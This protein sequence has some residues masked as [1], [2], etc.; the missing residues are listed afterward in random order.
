MYPFILALKMRAVCFCRA[1]VPTSVHSIKT[2]NNIIVIL[3]AMIV[4]DLKK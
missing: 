4:P 1:V 3:S 2:Q